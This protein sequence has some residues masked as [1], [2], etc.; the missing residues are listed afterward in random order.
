M[1]TNSVYLQQF[2]RSITQNDA[3]RFGH[4]FF[5]ELQGGDLN[6]LQG[7][8]GNEAAD[9]NFTFYIRSTNIPKTEIKSGTVN[10]LATSFA[11]PGVVSYPEDWSVEILLNNDLTLYNRL[12]AWQDEISDFNLNAGR[13]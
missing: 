9:K 1:S 6:Y 5:V 3:F 8:S 11:V 7:L 10:F 12:R 13:K 4:Q 2:Y